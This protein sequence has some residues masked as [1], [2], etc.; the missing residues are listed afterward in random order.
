MFCFCSLLYNHP[1]RIVSVIDDADEQLS[2]LKLKLAKLNTKS[3]QPLVPIDFEKDDDL[4]H[5]MEFITAASN[6][7]AENYDIAPADRM[8]VDFSTFLFNTNLSLK[9]SNVKKL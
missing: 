2:D 4:N 3:I 7:R 9:M 1:E 8:K 6:L 5:H